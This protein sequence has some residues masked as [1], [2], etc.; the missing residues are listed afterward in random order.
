[1]HVAGNFRFEDLKI[2][3]LDINEKYHHLFR[4]FEHEIEMIS[5]V[6]NCAL[7]QPLYITMYILVGL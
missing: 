7:N 4:N 3:S 2:T 5:K 1:M 6:G